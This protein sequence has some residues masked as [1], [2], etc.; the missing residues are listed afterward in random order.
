MANPAV[1]SEVLALYRDFMRYG[2]KFPTYN[3]RDYTIRRARDA[4]KAHAGE[5]DPDKIQ[6]LIQK[7]K[8]DLEVVK[9][10]VIVGSLYT[11]GQK[12]VVETQVSRRTI[13]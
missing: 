6:A 1:Q 5:T 2:R 7:A 11:H 8:Q 10:Q 13:S 3:F 9:R 12:L 4:F